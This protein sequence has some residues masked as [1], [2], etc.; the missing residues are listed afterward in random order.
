M[1]YLPQ[2]CN[3]CCTFA[4]A[5]FSGTPVFFI[6][7]ACVRQMA[8]PAAATPLPNSQPQHPAVKNITSVSSA[9]IN[10]IFI[11]IVY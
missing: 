4:L 6:A 1:H 5:V 10:S 2:T 7:T 11:F 3:S 8:F 9:P